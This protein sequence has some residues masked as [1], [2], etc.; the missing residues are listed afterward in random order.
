[1][2]THILTLLILCSFSLFVGCANTKNNQNTE[3]EAVSEPVKQAVQIEGAVGTLQAELQVPALKEGEKC[4]LVIIMHGV[5]SS[6][7][8]PIL[9]EIADSLQEIG[10]ASI[11]F[12]FDGHGASD[13]EFVDMTVPLEVKDAL[14][15]YEYCKTLDF[16]SN[17]SLLGHS[18][19]GVVTSLVA[20]ELQGE[21]QSVVLM[22][23]AAVMEDQTKAGMMM[24]VRFDPN[25]VP[26]YIEV[27][28]H[29][30][31]RE[32]LESGQKLNIYERAAKYTG[33]VC[34][35]HGKADQVVP[36]TYSEKYK[37][38]YQN[39]QLHLIEG[40]SHLFDQHPLE[41]T[42]FAVDFLAAQTK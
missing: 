38:T 37:E 16:A 6:K 1:M 8:F 25:N 19:G 40:E 39:S 36:Y 41:A 17:I 21:I 9:T 15:V 28:N 3:Q 5:F 32:Y 11:R 14:A 30:V 29:H 34:L 22:A 18:Q 42:S 4:P 20:G 23:A 31:G 7:E 27:Y 26:E 35:I 2:K 33:P 13:G 24:G 12:D 10:I